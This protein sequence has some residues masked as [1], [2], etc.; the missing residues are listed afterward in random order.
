MAENFDNSN[1]NGTNSMK[2]SEKMDLVLLIQTITQYQ[3]GLY[4][5]DFS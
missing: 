5:I 2:Y 1:K 3:I 4:G